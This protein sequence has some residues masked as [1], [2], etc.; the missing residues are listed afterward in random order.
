MEEPTIDE[1]FRLFKLRRG[2]DFAAVK[3]AYRKNLYKCHPDRFQGK[4]DLLPVAERKTK[5]LVQVYGIL[6]QWYQAHGGADMA[7]FPRAGP[8]RSP[9][10]PA[11]DPVEDE[12]LAPFYRRLIFWLTV[13]GIALPF[14]GFAW[15]FNSGPQAKDASSLVSGGRPPDPVAT[16][17]EQQS[18]I[19]NPQAP[20]EATAAALT[21]MTAERDRE[22]AAWVADYLR[23]AEAEHRA[24]EREILDS[25]AQFARDV[26]QKESELTEAED[27][28]ARQTDRAAKN[29]AAARQT[30]ARQEQ[31]V[32]DK[33]KLD[34]DAW[35]LAR[36]KEAVATVKSLREREH[37]EIGVFSDTEAPDKIFEFW[38]AEEAGAPEI[39]IAAKT[40]VTVQ[41]PDA[42]FFPHF[43]SNIFLYNPEGQ[44][45]VHTMEAIVERHATLTAELDER[46][47]AEES[48]LANWDARHPAGPVRLS[49]AQESALKARDAAIG[50]LSQ[51]K[52][53]LTASERALDPSRANIAFERSTKGLEWAERIRATRK[54]LDSA[55]ASP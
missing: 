28:V 22:K 26:Q 29:S 27:E 10:A 40:G 18:P 50:R 24:A 45:L 52:L 12:D 16:Q 39:N 42:R 49:A 4:P 35:L 5:R 3:Q 31:D 21:A 1:C 38:T 13:A 6:E 44:I 37:A 53:R 20:A 48:E 46:K 43:R 14:A 23:S 25:Q 34:Y 2:A 32:A 47:I 17:A 54:S 19:A 11:E 15:W 9:Q 55:A 30:F 8:E 33:L 41:Q 51:A 36:G 7:P